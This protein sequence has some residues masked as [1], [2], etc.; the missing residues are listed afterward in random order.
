MPEALL[1]TGNFNQSNI[2]IELGDPIH[3]STSKAFNNKNL[4]GSGT[5]AM[6]L[7]ISNLNTPVLF[8]FTNIKFAWIG[9][10]PS[11]SVTVDSINLYATYDEYRNIKMPLT[12]LSGSW[13]AGGNSNLSGTIPDF[14]RIA[15]SSDLYKFAFYLTVSSSYNGSNESNFTFSFDIDYYPINFII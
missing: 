9:T 11:Y 6:D 14:T 1:S 8:K 15:V 10:T 4:Y 7:N 3:K 5:F 2:L 13:E 12:I